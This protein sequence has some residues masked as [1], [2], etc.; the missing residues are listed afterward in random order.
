MVTSRPATA[1]SLRRAWSFGS[2]LAGTWTLRCHDVKLTCE[3]VDGGAAPV[4]IGQA[5]SF[6]VGEADHA[7]D[8]MTF[9]PLSRLTG[10][11]Q[12]P[13]RPKR[14]R[15]RRGGRVRHESG[16]DHSGRLTRTVDLVHASEWVFDHQKRT[17]PVP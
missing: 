1:F 10:Q 5:E 8:A 4:V 12:P 14:P 7:P 3:L 13:I 17:T 2:S 11:I 15:Q 16:E 6:G 9:T